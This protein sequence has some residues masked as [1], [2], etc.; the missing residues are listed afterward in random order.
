MVLGPGGSQ[1]HAPPSS[2][3]APKPGPEPRGSRASPAA[4]RAAPSAVPLPLCPPPARRAP[5]A[6]A[7]V[8]SYLLRGANV[9]GDRQ[10]L[11]LRRRPV[12]LATDSRASAEARGSP[13]SFAVQMHTL[14]RSSPGLGGSLVLCTW[15]LSERANLRLHSLPSSWWRPLQRLA[16]L[17]ER[18]KKDFIEC[19]DREQRQK[20]G[21]RC[22]LYSR[23]GKRKGAEIVGRQRNLC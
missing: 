7:A 16:R 6:W 14:G 8:V 17:R 20:A 22:S 21:G 2:T 23:G 18:L 11:Q 1:I 12:P 13:A 4:P 15:A 19:E 5:L 10:T 9:C 3:P